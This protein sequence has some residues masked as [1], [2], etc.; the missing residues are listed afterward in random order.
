MVVLEQQARTDQVASLLGEIACRIGASEKSHANHRRLAASTPRCQGL[1]TIDGAARSRYLLDV[2]VRP[3]DVPPPLRAPVSKAEHRMG[4]RTTTK[5]WLVVPRGQVVPAGVSGLRPVRDF[6]MRK[7][8]G[9]EPC[10][11]CPVLLELVIG[12]GHPDE[13]RPH[14]LAHPGS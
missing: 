5:V 8:R 12:V 9:L 6:I 14:L 4:A 11:R 13:A 10:C 1:T 7:A 3:L 2:R